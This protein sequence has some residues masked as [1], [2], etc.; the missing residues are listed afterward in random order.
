MDV[1][2]CARTKYD[3][4]LNHLDYGYVSSCKDKKELEK[5][6]KILR[7]CIVVSFVFHMITC[8]V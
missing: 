8:Y 6:V 7:L 3:I 4:P 2:G 5:I 1:Y